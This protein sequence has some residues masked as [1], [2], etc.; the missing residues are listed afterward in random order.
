MT[1][2]PPIRTR[3]FAIM[4]LSFAALIAREFLRSKL[5][6]SGLDGEYA[7]DLSFL[8]VPPILIVLMWPILRQHADHLREILSFRYL[9]LRTVAFGF[10]IGLFIRVAWWSQVVFRGSYGF[11]QNP[12]PDA[13]VGPTFHLHCPPLHVIMLGIV[14]MA[15]L[16]PVIEE[17]TH[18]GLL[19]SAFANRGPVFAIVVSSVLFTMFHAWHSLVFVFLV[20]LVLGLQYWRTG[21]L[22]FG[23]VTHATYNGLSQLDW[24]CLNIKWNPTPEQLPLHASGI[25][26][27][28][29][30]VLTVA[31]TIWLAFNPNAG[32]RKAPR[33]VD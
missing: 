18:R 30:F 24:R 28:V 32:A 9:T 4:L 31:L 5:N 3:V 8:V 11:I 12:N 6:E 7:E 20:G 25:V 29:V 22:W 10:L 16:V 26:S 15:A 14:V 23:I 1:T 13:I 2:A 33:P 19:L 17:V 21:A 27:A